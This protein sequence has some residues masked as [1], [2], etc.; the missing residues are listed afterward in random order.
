MAL[1]LTSDETLTA[2]LA[3]SPAPALLCFIAQSS[4]PSRV[5]QPVLEELSREYGRLVRFASVDADA[6]PRAL[7]HYGILSLPTYLFLRN[8]RITG[9]F[10]GAM[11]RD[12]L[13][14]KIEAALKLTG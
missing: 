13:V 9:R 14:E 11:A 7:N 4:R 10:V 2:F 1:S 12:T 6:S 8:G 3:A 5:M